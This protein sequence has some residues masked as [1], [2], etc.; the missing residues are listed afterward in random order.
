MSPTR[1]PDGG[2]VV[3]L[4][5]FARR[6]FLICDCELACARAV[7]RFSRFRVGSDRGCESGSERL[8]DELAAAAIRPGLEARARTLRTP[9][10]GFA[11][12]AADHR[13]CDRS[14]VGR[15]RIPRR[16]AGSVVWLSIQCCQS[17][18]A[19]ILKMPVSPV[20]PKPRWES[21]VILRSSTAG[22]ASR[23]Q[24]VEVSSGAMSIRR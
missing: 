5:K 3:F 14:P 11:R 8:I 15:R 1:P 7:R 22:F 23:G 20:L 17:P 2:R 12:W 10:R 6:T 21:G 13:L 24:T 18:Q 16:Q 19:G 9:R 4:E